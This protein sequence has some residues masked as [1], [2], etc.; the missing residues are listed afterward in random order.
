MKRR[1]GFTLVELLAVL[2]IL[3]VMILIVANLVTKN[4]QEAKNEITKSQEKAI[5]NA[6]EKWSVEHSDVFDDV[7]GTTISVGLD[8]VFVVDVSGS[9]ASKLSGSSVTRYEGTENAINSALEILK[10]SDKNRVGFVFYSGL[11]SSRGSCENQTGTAN[12][13]CSVVASFPL[14]PVGSYQDITHG[15]HYWHNS[16]WEDKVPYFNVNGTLVDINGGTYTWIGLQKARELFIDASKEETRIP[17]VVLLTDGEPTYGRKYDESAVFSMANSTL[18]DG[19]TSKLEKNPATNSEIIWSIMKTSYQ[20][21][22][23]LGKRYQSDVFYYTIG[24]GI[25]SNYGTF[26][27]NPSPDNYAALNSSRTQLDKNLYSFI[28]NKSD[29]KY[30]YPTQSFTGEISEDALK[31]IFVDIATQ[32][33]EATKVTSVC[34]TVEDLYNSG[35]L[36]TNEIDLDG[37]TTQD[38]LMNYNEPTHQYSFN[39]VK[40][41]EQKKVCN[42]YYASKDS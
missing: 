30:N 25:T 11:I 38:V 33:T 1:K 41:E 4:V 23:D 19:T 26:M 6:A 29:K 17:V 22:E 10:Q 9:M 7:E 37:V 2:V 36:S 18:G 14:K 28:N 21:K 16:R 42:A 3:S 34:I 8:L 40:T 13:D 39:L 12:K 32:V 31:N 15:T 24:I 5:L 20:L 27:L 35:Y